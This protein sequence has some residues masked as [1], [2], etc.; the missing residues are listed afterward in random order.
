MSQSVLPN[1]AVVGAGLAGLACARR[2]QDAGRRVLVFD[3]GR[4]LGGRL[5]TRR[6]GDAGLSF[7]HGAQFVTARGEGFRALL[8][9]ARAEGQAAPWHPRIGGPAGG[10]T[11]G[12]HVG[13]PGMARLVRPLA[14]GLEVRTGT[15]IARLEAAAEGWRLHADD[16]AVHGPFAALVLAIPHVQAA[17]LLD[18]RPEAGE[19]AGVEVAPC[20]AAMLAFDRPLD[21]GLD[22]WRSDAGP[23]ALAAR[24]ASKPGR[25]AQPETWVLHGAPEWSAAH[26]EDSPDAVLPRL[27]DAFATV[28]GPLPEPV[29]AAAHR[30]RY[31]RTIAPLGR[32]FAAGGRLMIG[33]DWCLGARA[34]AAFDSGTAM[35]EQILTAGAVTA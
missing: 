35:A 7:D 31:A 4:G 15:R 1:V 34:E 2:L 13:T 20:W 9:L 16:A 3:K 17:E 23:L 22:L 27:L 28:A 29:H 33:G 8:H 11:E 18:G 30:W 14:E 25:P 5:A 32:P 6:I 26:L 12:W 21:A 10:A 24:N 19:I